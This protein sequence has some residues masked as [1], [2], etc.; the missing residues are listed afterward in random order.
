MDETG[1]TVKPLM[2]TAAFNQGL[3]YCMNPHFKDIV[4]A[5]THAKAISSEQ[6][7]QHLWS[8]YGKIIKVGLSEAAVPSAILK[9]ISLPDEI[10]H[11]QGWDT[12]LSHARKIKSYDVEIHWYQQWSTRCPPA[13]RVA[14]CF[15]ASSDEHEHVIVL[16][17][18][19]AAGFPLRKS[20]LSKAEAKACLKWLA[21]FHATFLNEAPDGLWEVGSYWHLDTRPDELEAMEESDLKKCAHAIDKALNQCKYKTVIHGDAKVAN[22]C[23]SSD[24]QH[25]AAVDFQYVG[26]GC[27]M[28][29]VAYF[30][31]SCLS[32]QQCDQ[33]HAELLDD[34]FNELETA[35][36][37]LD[38]CVDWDE[39][40]KE[41]EEM[42][43][44]AWADFH[45][46]LL[47]WMPTHHK[48]NVFSERMAARAVGLFQERE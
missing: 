44:V 33:W 26:G 11:P 20:N 21:N 46:F 31:G 8:D 38:K 4:V 6:V 32:E 15:I 48:V 16:E 45:R 27:G 28:K 10:N 24:G 39:L 18:L 3:P 19:D 23:F 34:Y 36:D 29:D 17:D 40:R 42:F 47:G 43:P 14:T 1:Y 12:I 9:Y 2:F 25:V 30:L 5:S 35:L 41:W 22:F 7:I 37:G 13:C